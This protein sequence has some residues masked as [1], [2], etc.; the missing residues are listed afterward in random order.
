[1]A[2]EQA[3]QV[4]RGHAER[5]G[6]LA[7]PGLAVEEP[8]LDQTQ[9]PRHRG[10]RA[11]PRRC[12]RGGLGPTSEAR[13]EPRTLGRGRGREEHD[14]LR[15]RGLHRTRGPAVDSR[16]PDTRVERA[17]EARVAGDARTI[18]G[19]GIE[20][21]EVLHTASLARAAAP[22]AARPTITSENGETL[23]RAVDSVVPDA[24]EVL[25]RLECGRRHV[26]DGARQ[27]RPW[28]L[29]DRRVRR[30]APANP[31]LVGLG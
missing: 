5:V 16:R 6:E 4:A 8:A 11:S 1:M 23:T 3:A 28:V 31:W 20:R 15:L 10:C 29:R 30:G 17:V 26:R 9:R 27:L 14:V 24:P 2:Q 18:A 19:L 7:Y 12:S 13:P 25:L 21:G 22:L